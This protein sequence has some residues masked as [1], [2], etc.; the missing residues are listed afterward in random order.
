M[1][2]VVQQV[3]IARKN[4]HMIPKKLR[5]SLI[6]FKVELGGQVIKAGYI[7]RNLYKNCCPSVTR[8]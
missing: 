2:I 4:K 1:Y 3:R 8:L 5:K 6:Y 7:P